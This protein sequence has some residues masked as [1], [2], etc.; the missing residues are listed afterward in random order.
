M[1]RSAYIS[2]C[3]LYRY[4]LSRDWDQELSC[5]YWIMLNPSTAD[6]TKDDPTIRRCINYSKAWG[7]GGAA[8][9]NLFAYRATQVKNL[10]Q[11]A[12]DGVDIIGPEN[13]RQLDNIAKIVNPKRSKDK[14]GNVTVRQ[15][16]DIAMIAWGNH[17]VLQD[18]AKEVLSILEEPRYLRVNK[19]TGQPGHPLYLPKKLTPVLWTK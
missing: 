2:E 6:A 17:G 8:I 12:K 14:R 19:A 4:T 16:S 13:N 7:F 5:V 18:R 15:K 10:E 9:L 11:A 3:G 1:I